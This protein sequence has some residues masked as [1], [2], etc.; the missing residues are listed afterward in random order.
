[1]LHK[2]GGF[3]PAFRKESDRNERNHIVLETVYGD[4]VVTQIAGVFARRI[5][6]YITRDSEVV[7]G[8]RIGMIRYGSRVDVTLPDGFEILVS[9]GD[10]VRCGETIVARVVGS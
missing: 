9:P 3:V 8:Q 7:R 2:R 5:V 6:T 1:V 10:R 4:V